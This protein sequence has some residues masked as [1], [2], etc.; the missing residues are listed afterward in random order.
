MSAPTTTPAGQLA[1]H[2]PM[3]RWNSEGQEWHS[4][5]LVHVHAGGDEDHAHIVTTDPAVRARLTAVLTAISLGQA[6]PAQSA[7]A[8]MLLR[9]VV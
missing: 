3:G 2:R 4:H 7:E 1:E 9:M 5:T 8:A 6:G